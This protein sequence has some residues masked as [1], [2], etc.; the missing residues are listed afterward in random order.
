[1][2]FVVKITSKV[3]TY[4]GDAAGVPEYTKMIEDAQEKA[5]WEKLPVPNTTLMSIS[6]KSILQAQA[7]IP[8]IN[9]W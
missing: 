4:Y 1:M 6:T 9:K 7:F 2:I 5:Q 8:K 3:L